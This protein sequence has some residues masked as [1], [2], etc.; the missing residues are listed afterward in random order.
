M[1]IN[2]IG[3]IA[4]AAVLAFTA[5]YLIRSRIGRSRLASAEHQA[6]GVIEQAAREAESV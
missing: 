1:D 2:L 5:G 3:G 6:R 4:I